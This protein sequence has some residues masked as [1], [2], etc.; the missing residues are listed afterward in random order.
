MCEMKLIP[1]FGQECAVDP[2]TKM[3]HTSSQTHE[4]GDMHKSLNA[5]LLTNQYRVRKSILVN[6][7]TRYNELTADMPPIQS[8]NSD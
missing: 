7:Q 5:P 3:I 2:V 8:N 1:E 4:F 6:A